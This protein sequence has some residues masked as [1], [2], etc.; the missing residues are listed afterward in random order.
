MRI[1]IEA[2]ICPNGGRR[3]VMRKNIKIGAKNGIKDKNTASELSGALMINIMSMIGIIK[4][5]VTGITNCWASFSE[6]TMEPMA[7]KRVPKRK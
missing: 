3:T 7:A 6:L 2:P 4:N 1:T 5:M